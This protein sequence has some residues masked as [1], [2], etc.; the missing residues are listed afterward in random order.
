MFHKY[1]DSYDIIG[2]SYIKNNIKVETDTKII[3]NNQFTILNHIKSPKEKNILKK[4]IN[5]FKTI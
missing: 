1:G 2:K 4:N 3:G 5:A